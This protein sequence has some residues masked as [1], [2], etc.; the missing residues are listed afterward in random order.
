MAAQE[1]S[2]RAEFFKLFESHPSASA[3]AEWIFEACARAYF[4]SPER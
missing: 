2:Q 4:M 3:T 1:I